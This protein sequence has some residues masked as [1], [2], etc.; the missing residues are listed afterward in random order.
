MTKF[1]CFSV[2]VAK[3][4]RMDLEQAFFKFYCKLK[5]DMFLMLSEVAA[6]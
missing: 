4:P 2:Y 3:R 6:S 5:N 1:S